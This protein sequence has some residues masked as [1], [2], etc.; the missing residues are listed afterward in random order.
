MVDGSAGTDAGGAG[1]WRSAFG[2]DGVRGGMGPAAGTAT[3]AAGGALAGM[4]GLG[5]GGSKHTASSYGT[6]TLG[7]MAG[8]PATM[9][10]PTGVSRQVPRAQVPW[11]QQRGATEVY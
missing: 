10:A 7:A 9:R 4:F 1:A 5:G 3:K 2:L 11:Y 8:G 6:P